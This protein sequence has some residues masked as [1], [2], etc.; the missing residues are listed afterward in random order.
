MNT[1]KNQGPYPTETKPFG[2]VPVMR[3]ARITSASS[4]ILLSALVALVIVVG[5]YLALTSP[6]THPAVVRLAGASHLEELARVKDDVVPASA[7]F[8]GPSRL[9]ELERIKSDAIPAS[10]TLSGPSRLEELEYMKG[11][12]A[13]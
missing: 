8:S 3:R 10:A 13:P 7:A 4:I 11:T 9:E 12:L 2:V 1:L 5:A 6:T